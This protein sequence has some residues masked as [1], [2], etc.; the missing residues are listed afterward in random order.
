MDDPLKIFEWQVLPFGTTCSPCCATYALQ[1]HVID[2]SQEGDDIRFS[3]E[4][5]F[6]VDNCLQSLRT[7]EEAKLLVDK[8]RE[9]LAGAGFELRQWACN[10]LSVLSHL[11]QEAQSKSLELWLA[12]DKS[13]PLESTLGLSWNWQTDTLG[14]KHRPVAYDALT[15][16]NIYKVLATQYDPLGFL[17][18]YTTRAKIIIRQLWNKQRGWD[19]PNLPTDLLQSWRSWEAELQCLPDIILP[20]AYVPAEVDQNVTR[21]VH[22][23]SDASKQAYGAV[24]YMRIVSMPNQIH[25]SFILARSQLAPKRLHSIARL[26][27][28]GALVAAQLARLL[29]GE[30]TLP[31]DRNVIPQQ[32]LPG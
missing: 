17:L 28:C 15:L 31:I 27:L 16:R 30:L 26:E 11:P 7:K 8:L 20:R 25:L 22:I 21:E 3:V 29:A 19:E 23:F 13:N 4:K 18:P 10:V 6:Y 5:C 14:Y 24:A 9:L 2:H 1:Q 32:S 12:Q